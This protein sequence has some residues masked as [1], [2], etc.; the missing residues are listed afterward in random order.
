MAVVATHSGASRLVAALRKNCKPIASWGIGFGGTRVSAAGACQAKVGS[1]ASAYSRSSGQTSTSS[2]ESGSRFAA[3]IPRLIGPEN[4]VLEVAR[5]WVI[6][7]AVLRKG[8]K[9]QR[10]GENHPRRATRFVS[11]SRLEMLRIP[12]ARLANLRPRDHEQAGGGGSRPRLPAPGHR[13]DIQG[14]RAVAVVLVVLD[15]G[16]VPFFKG[17][18]VGV[19]VFFVLSGFLITG[20]LLAGAGKR[21]YVSLIDFYVR[22]ARRILPAAALTLAATDIAAYHFLNVVRARQVMWDSIW[23]SFFAANIH[24]AHQATN[25]FARDQ[26]PSPVQHYW[27]LAVEEQFYLVWPVLVALVVFGLVLGHRLVGRR[28]VT[29]HARTI[30][31]LASRRLLVLVALIGA[32]SLAWSIYDTSA[33]PSAAYF[34]TFARAW[35][36]ALGAALAIASSRLTK[37]PAVSRTV[38]GWLGLLGIACAAT[39]FS[40]RT[41][42]P[43]Y[44][45]LLPTFGA[46]LV[47]GAGIG[48]QLPAGVGRLLSVRPMRYVGDRSYAFYLWHWPV[49]TIMLQ[50]EGHD[51]SVGVK[52]ILLLGAFLLSI[53]TYRFFED[54]IRRAR[55]SAP[56]TALLWP[57]SIASVVVIAGITLQLTDTHSLRA[58]EAA[59]ATG[60]SIGRSAT[61]GALPSVIA[62]VKAA[63]RGAAIPS[64]LTPPVT[65]LLKDYYDPAA[66]AASD[67]QTTS[68][69]CP[70]GD[71]SASRSIAVVGD[72]HAY[73]WMPAI[74]RMAQQDGWKVVL[75]GKS[76]CTPDTWTGHQTGA[77]NGTP[78]WA[79]C[80]TWYRWGVGQAKALKPTV[81]V[82]TGAYG[83]VTGPS[84]ASFV[85]GIS[86][87]TVTMKTFSKAVVVI[88]DTPRQTRQPVDCL[89]ARHATMKTCTSLFPQEMWQISDNIAAG[90]KKHGAAFLSTRGWF[91]FDYQCPMVVGHTIVYRD[92]GHVT[93]TYA[94]KVPFR[95]AFDQAIL[96]QLTK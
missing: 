94:L 72:S 61:G 76:G 77:R 46:A 53:I 20:L 42:Y 81:T 14:L 58:A 12:A 35:E 70:V 91:C 51:L 8:P 39:L 96:N 65:T 80:R 23:A 68:D 84:A 49:L 30:T 66:C 11:T 56:R 55:W 95:A 64:G 19:D 22:R 73:M 79:E 85:S 87:A 54:P 33:S 36:L 67:G 24:F 10:R 57:A 41:A 34:S 89:L 83:G 3:A 47:I 37:V 26:P 52:L 75:I 40:S 7:V 32:M 29:A 71:P 6:V 17:G 62:A 60:S 16:G 15:H 45:A 50:Y 43:G 93:K 31:E 28:P 5:F 82:I 86:S 59:A 25:Y 9:A 4:A 69:I 74:V 38:I 21:G 90:V 78:G 88:G 63:Q 44:A 1:I 48:N 18:Y 92:T 27:S 13:N 2:G